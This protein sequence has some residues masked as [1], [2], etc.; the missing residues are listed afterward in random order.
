MF[1][2]HNESDAA[3]VF[4]KLVPHST[5][6]GGGCCPYMGLPNSIRRNISV[7]LPHTCC[8]GVLAVNMSSGNHPGFKDC[9]MHAKAVS[10]SAVDG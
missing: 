10:K 6:L 2:G 4:Y 1:C 5:W 7:E 8:A 9:S 3:Q